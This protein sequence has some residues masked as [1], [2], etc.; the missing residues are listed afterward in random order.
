[1]PEDTAIIRPFRGIRYNTTESSDLSDLL[2][3]PYDVISKAEQKRLYA[4]S[5]HNF[6]RIELP[7]GPSDTRYAEAARTLRAWLADGILAREGSPVF[8]VLEQE[9]VAQGRTWRRRGIFCLVRLPEAGENHVLSHEG[10][11]PEPKADRLLLMGSCRAMTS[12][13]MAMLA[14]EDRRLIALLGQVTGEPTAEARDRDG[15]RHTLW[16]VSEQSVGADYAW[17]AENGP[18]YI[19]DGHHRYETAIAYRDHMRTRLPRARSDAAFNYALCLVNSAR[20]EGLRIYPTHRLVSG[21]GAAGR[22][23]LRS[24]MEQYFEVDETPVTDRE[25]AADLSWLEETT[26]G[27]PVIGAYDGGHLYQLA[28]RNDAV[29]ASDRVVDRLDV[30]VLHRRLID[31]A[32]AG[33]GCALDSN[34]RVSHDS[35]AAGPTRRGARLTYATDAAQAMRAVDRGDY[36]YAFFLRPTRVSEVI[37]AARAGERMPGKST[38]FYPKIPAGLVLSDASEGP[39]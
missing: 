14:D 8:Y 21:L 30:S 38:Y 35:E 11:L 16:T 25:E 7:R 39:V 26:P 31:P 37:E 4:V 2:A 17:A 23:S 18:L 29:P 1:M 34:G 10:T 12:P 28:G 27:R 24:C 33:T 19:A 13:I 20:D 36:D 6:V 22:E 15:V 32:L 9:F 5:R 3:P